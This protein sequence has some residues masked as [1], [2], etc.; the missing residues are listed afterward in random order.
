MAELKHGQNRY[1]GDPHFP[2]SPLQT[3]VV[4]SREKGQRTTVRSAD[5]LPDLSLQRNSLHS[6][7]NPETGEK[8]ESARVILARLFD[9]FLPNRLPLAV[10]VARDR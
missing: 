6:H 5:G 2:K 8:L 3:F 4:P 10:D 7:V 1:A 9:H